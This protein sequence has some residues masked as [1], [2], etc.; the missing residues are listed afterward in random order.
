M[1]TKYLT[2]IISLL[3]VKIVI[4][5]NNQN[6]SEEKFDYQF[7]GYIQ[8]REFNGTVNMSDNI[9]TADKYR[10]NVI[11]EETAKIENNEFEYVLLKLV[12]FGGGYNFIRRIDSTKLKS[13]INNVD[14]VS[15][16]QITEINKKTDSVLDLYKILPN[17]S[18]T[19][20][21]FLKNKRDSIVKL[22][23]I[24]INKIKTKIPFTKDSIYKKANE[25]TFIKSWNKKG[26]FKRFFTSSDTIRYSTRFIKNYVDVSNQDKVFW[27][28]KDKFN[29]HI[30]KGYIQKRYQTPIQ[31]AYGA[32]LS[33]PFKIRPNIKEQN[34][35]ITPEISL[36][37]YFGLRKRLNRYKPIYLYFPVI[38]A[39]VTTIGI[40]NNNVIDESTTTPSNVE[41][42]LVFARTFSIGSFVEFN[43]F[44]MGFVAGWDKG[45]GEIAKNWIYNDQLWYSFSIGYN[46]LRRSD[47][48]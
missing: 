23:E 18:D 38:T 26:W 42:G 44:Q 28:K 13:L 40:N 25:I 31:F 2:I 47:S 17:L 24:K 46:F 1:K 32:S 12:K 35:K 9:W 41:D 29:K 11:G 27:L 43:S 5:Q 4:A 33:I 37:G 19:E 30:E 15:L 22:K 10:F 21:S 14:L 7:K 34:M 6:N 8:L 48:N 3:F 16:T 45:G 36:G 20:K 39:G